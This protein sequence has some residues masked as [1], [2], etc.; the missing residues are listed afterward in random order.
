ML[1][2]WTIHCFNIVDLESAAAEQ[3]LLQALL[4]S[5]ANRQVLP[6]IRYCPSPS[7]AHREVLPTFTVGDT[8]ARHFRPPPLFPSVTIVDRYY[9]SSLCEY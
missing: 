4:S 8:I 6:V 1:R 5:I 3:K 9:T 2:R 7:I